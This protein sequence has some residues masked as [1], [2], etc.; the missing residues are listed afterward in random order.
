MIFEFEKSDNGVS[1]ELSSMEMI[2]NHAGSP[3]GPI[4]VSE[5]LSSMEMMI[6]RHSITPRRQVSEEL[7]SMEIQIK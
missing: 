4:C 6:P 3:Y 2:F 7:S 1:E 5:E